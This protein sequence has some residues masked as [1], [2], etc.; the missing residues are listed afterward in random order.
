MDCLSRWHFFVV[1]ESAVDISDVGL[2]PSLWIFTPSRIMWI[3]RLDVM[4]VTIRRRAGL[5]VHRD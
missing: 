2:I 5:V 1:P 4:M 3:T